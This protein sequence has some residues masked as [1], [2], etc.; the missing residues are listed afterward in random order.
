MAKLKN[1]GIFKLLG[2]KICRKINMFKLRPNMEQIITILTYVTGKLCSFFTALKL[3]SKKKNL[4]LCLFANLR[5]PAGEAEAEA[6]K[7]NTYSI[8]YMLPLTPV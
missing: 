5:R 6:E 4:D 7:P 2:I 1:I 3:N 8:F